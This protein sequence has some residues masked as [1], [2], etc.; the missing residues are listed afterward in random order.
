M[1]C[2]ICNDQCMNCSHHLGRYTVFYWDGANVFGTQHKT[3]VY[4]RCDYSPVLMFDRWI[5]LDEERIEKLLVL[6]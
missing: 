2:P 1:I 4:L 3:A 6:I 5:A